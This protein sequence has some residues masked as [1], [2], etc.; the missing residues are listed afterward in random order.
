MN[1]CCLCLA[2]SLCQWGLCLF[3]GLFYHPWYLSLQQQHFISVPL[4]VCVVCIGVYMQ[5]S[6]FSY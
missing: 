2:L 6:L 3:L 4:S 5:L 1:R